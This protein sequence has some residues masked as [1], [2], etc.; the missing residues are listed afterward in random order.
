MGVCKPL[1]PDVVSSK[2]QLQLC[3][4]IGP[5]FGFTM[6]KF[7]MAGSYTENLK[8][9]QNYQNWGVGTCPGQYG[10]VILYCVIE[11]CHFNLYT[12]RS[13]LCEWLL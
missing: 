8:K 11:T 7:S 3:D 1:M 5:T 4:L 12:L 6:Q 2:A 10:T 13:Y 9:P